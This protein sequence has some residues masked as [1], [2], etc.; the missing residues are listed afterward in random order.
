MRVRAER[1]VKQIEGRRGLGFERCFDRMRGTAWQERG[2]AEKGDRLKY[3]E[4]S[5][6]RA[7]EDGDVSG[8]VKKVGRGG[9]WGGERDSFGKMSKLKQSKRVVEDAGK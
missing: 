3:G 7:A 6:W 5:L 9:L 2:R 8:S 1:D 4:R